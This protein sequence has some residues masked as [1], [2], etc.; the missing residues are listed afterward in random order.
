MVDLVP[1]I[2]S[3]FEGGDLVLGLAHQ[4]FLLRTHV[5]TGALCA[6]RLGYICRLSDVDAG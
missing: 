5:G 2:G 1:G 3:R 4:P 6:L